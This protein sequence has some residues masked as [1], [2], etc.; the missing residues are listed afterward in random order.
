MTPVSEFLEISTRSDGRRAVIEL[1]GELD[2]AGVPAFSSTVADLLD[3]PGSA[4]SID[5]DA[6]GLRFI[7]SAG[8]QALLVAQKEAADAGVELGIVK[9]SAAVDRILAM[10]GLD[11]Q[12]SAA[13]PP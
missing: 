13:P 1:G 12:L 6:R 4:R 7:D 9:S 2:L 5:L 8:L 11:Q 3:G 10:T